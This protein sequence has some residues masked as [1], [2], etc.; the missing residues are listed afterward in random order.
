MKFQ[1]LPRK[2]KLGAMSLEDPMPSGS[3]DQVVEVF[4]EQYPMV[5]FTRIFESD[6]VVSQCGLF[7][8]Y[9]IKLPP[10]KVNG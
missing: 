1:T 2:F 4:G 9:E 6:A 7:L 5:R 10:V 8:E 3:L